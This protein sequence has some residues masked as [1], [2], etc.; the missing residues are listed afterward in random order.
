MNIRRNLRL[1]L[2]GGSG[3]R[4][5]D[6]QRDRRQVHNRVDERCRAIWPARRPP[7]EKSRPD[8]VQGWGQGQIAEG[9]EAGGMLTFEAAA[10]K[11]TFDTAFD[12]AQAENFWWTPV[13]R[14]E[15]R[16][17]FLDLFKR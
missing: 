17:D 11:R 14:T 3:V 4:S 15:P 2:L 7:G 9:T 16:A 10:M 1:L 6:K 13:A 5:N 12:S 8:L